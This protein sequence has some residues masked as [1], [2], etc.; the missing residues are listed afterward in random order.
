[1]KSELTKLASESSLSVHYLPD[2][3]FPVWEQ[4]RN[5]PVSQNSDLVEGCQ[6][7]LR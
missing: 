6:N 4:V 2:T 1:M 5:I 7:E 3:V